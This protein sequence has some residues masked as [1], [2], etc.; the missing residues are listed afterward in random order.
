[1]TLTREAW[2]RE[3]TILV[4]ALYARIGAAPD[5]TDA[6]VIELSRTLR[7]LAGKP[8][9]GAF[10]SPDA[11]S[12]KLRTCLTLADGP[13]DGLTNASTLLA[14]VWS[15]YAGDVARLAGD[16]AVIAG[17]APAT[18][19]ATD[20]VSPV[21][22]MRVRRLDGTP[23]RVTFAREGFP[24]VSVDYADGLREK[25]SRDSFVKVETGVVYAIGD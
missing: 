17:Y 16:A 19:P 9:D 15:E 21:I 20:A 12:M 7:A 18:A 24:A 3:E 13:A 25:V 8:A 22:G 1:M 4:L 14:S 6:D 10:R 2:T 23:G 5:E 11:V